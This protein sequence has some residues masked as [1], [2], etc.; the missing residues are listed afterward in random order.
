MGMKDVYTKGF[1]MLVE[2][3]HMESFRIL[4]CQNFEEAAREGLVTPIRAI[5]ACNPC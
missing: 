2:T 4:Q 5:N 1:N 3:E